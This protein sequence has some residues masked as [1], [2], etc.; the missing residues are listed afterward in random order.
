[1]FAP[2]RA[3]DPLP[4]VVDA[5]EPFHVVIAGGGVAA[6]EAALALRTLGAGDIDVTMIAPG[7]DFIYRPTSVLEPFAFGPAGRHPLDEIAEDVGVELVVD[8]LAWLDADQ[9]V[10]YTAGE[11]SIGYDALILALGATPHPR[12]EHALTIDDRRIDEILHGLIEDVEGG[13]VHR[14]AFVVPPR[15]GWPLPIYELALM[16]ARRAYDMNVGLD[17]KIVT[18]ELAP[19]ALFGDRASAAVAAL[20]TDRGIDLITGSSCEVPDGRHIVVNPGDR[21]L[22]VDRVVALPELFGPAVRGLPSAD[23][24]F[25]PIDGLCR[26]RGVDR[27]YAAGDATDYPLKHGG[28]AA[29]QA[30]TAAQAIAAIA[31]RAGEPA[32]LDPTLHGI[33]LTGAAPLQLSAE[34]IDGE[35]S[36][37]AFTGVPNSSP[38][39]KIQAR[40]L[41][42]YLDELDRLETVAT[43]PTPAP[44]TAPAPAS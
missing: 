30:D 3:T 37:A 27:V 11:L 14:L 38:P 39:R 15:L 28:I 31:G 12:Y 26:V 29:Q 32:P 8:S 25:I 34:I 24:G 41:A 16:T 10:A 42:P 23:H 1:M 4:V 40:Y 18:P 43:G 6:L 20:L 5:P 7:E 22:T 21:R 35:V 9:R 17:V 44:A 33:L 19:L 36:S 13:Y 2:S